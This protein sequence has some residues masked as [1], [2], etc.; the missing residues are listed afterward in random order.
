MAD[1]D[2]ILTARVAELEAIGDLRKALDTLEGLLDERQFGKTAALGYQDIASA[3]I[4][5]QPPW[6]GY[7]ALISIV[8][9]SPQASQKNCNAPM[10][11]Q[12]L[13]CLRVC[14]A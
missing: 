1:A 4:F 8:T 13:M 12:N 6:A 5:L 2:R 14:N 9:P 3:F 7:R 11:M 10:K